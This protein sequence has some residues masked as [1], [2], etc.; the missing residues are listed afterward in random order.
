MS[1]RKSELSE[2]RNELIHE[3]KFAGHPI[4]FGYPANCSVWDTEFPRFVSVLLLSCIGVK[5]EFTNAP[6]TSY[7]ISG[8]RYSDAPAN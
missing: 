1:Q 8:F 4:G 7:Q 5:N 2:L 3:A 6:V